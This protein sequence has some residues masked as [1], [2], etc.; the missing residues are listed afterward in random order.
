V[1]FVHAARRNK[2]A[3]A[4]AASLRASMSPKEWKD[5]EKMLKAQGL[6]PQKVAEVLSSAKP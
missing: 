5:A 1:W 4:A 2:D 3:I 6:D